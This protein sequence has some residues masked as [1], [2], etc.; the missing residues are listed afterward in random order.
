MTMLFCIAESEIKVVHTMSAMGSGKEEYSPHIYFVF[1][2][3]NL[4]RC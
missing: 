2:S 3:T 4:A 1:T